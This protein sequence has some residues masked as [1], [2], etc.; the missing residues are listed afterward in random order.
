MA[1]GKQCPDDLAQENE[2]LR[3]RLRVLEDAIDNM[4]PGLC[5]F[6]ADRRI[7][8]C[9]PRFS[10]L[11][12]FPEGTIGP[13]MTSR[14]LVEKGMAVGDY[15]AG[16]T[17]D[18]L[19]RLLWHNLTCADAERQPL[20]R[21]GQ[22]FSA[23]PQRTPLGNLVTTFHDITYRTRTE[24]ALRAS[25][26]RLTA[27]L[28]AMPEAVGIYDTDGTLVYTNPQGLELLQADSLEQLAAA[29]TQAVASEYLDLC[30]DVHRRVIAGE[31]INWT[32]EMIG[33]KGRR[34]HVEANSVPFRAPDGAHQRMCIARDVTARER[35]QEALRLSEERLRLVQEATGLADFEVGMDGMVICSKRF[36][37]QTGLPVDTTRLSIE[38]WCKI[39][40]PEDLARV[41]EEI[42]AALKDLASDVCRNEFRIVRCDNGE[43]RW[44]SSLTTFQRDDRGHT[45]RSIGSHL[46]VTNRKHAEE[47]LRVSEERFRFAAEA[48]G[49]GVWD[50][51]PKTGQR[52]WSDRLMEILGLEPDVEPSLELASGQVHPA[53]REVFIERL[54]ELR[55]GTGPNRFTLSF[56]ITRA[57]DRAERWVA[58]NGWR[59]DRSEGFRRIILTARDV[60]EEKTAE[61]RIRWSASHDGLTRLANRSAFQDRLDRAIQTARTN[62]TQAGLLMIDLDHFK[63]INDALGHDAGDKLLQAFA[64]RLR[65]A[66]RLGD[67][68]ARFGGDE[69]AVLVPDLPSG[70]DLAEL[71]RSIHERLREP[72]IQ[73]GRLLDCRISVGAAIYPLHG[74]TPRDL[75]ISADMALYAAKTAGRS[76]TVEYRPELRHEVQRFASMVSLAR[77]AVQEDRILPFYQPQLDLGTGKIVGFEA[78]LRWRDSKNAVH[79][80]STIEAAFE[81]HEVAADISDRIIECAIGDMRLWLDDGVDFGHIAVNASA[82]EFRRDDFGERVLES[83]RRANI[84]S[85]YFQLEVTETVFLGRGAEFV[86]R[87]LGLLSSEG[88]KIALDDFGTGYASLRHLKQFPVDILKIDQ[89]FVRDMGKEPGDEAIIRAVVNLG[90]NLNIKVVAEGIENMRQAKRLI[91]LGCDF[92]QGFLFSKAVPSERVPP[93][94][95]HLPQRAREQRLRVAAGRV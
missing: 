5:V 41:R 89:S 40:H 67:T 84:P 39:I 64:Q 61:D 18:E 7:A 2:R 87:A 62:K 14:E 73:D 46:D 57:S 69:F 23:R 10:E 32:Y 66:V 79:L 70:Q 88:V 31:S 30:A 33:L 49:M 36:V 1:G 56:R 20:T 24:Q 22:V 17:A 53:D 59:A 45:V 9:N 16:M 90:K 43:V 95:S 12:G 72:F 80:P 77:R 38:E 83:L 25:E 47:A 4:I 6:D 81:D 91:E 3:A 65:G 58:I 42:A 94:L 93:L 19:D 85:R 92:G 63:Q 54:T 71:C 51:D 15:P 74:A 50:Y 68:V 48:A 13:G 11:L 78:L 21:G 82:A 35:N 37:E 27:I 28:G 52:E 86:H 29:G 75:L 60:T 8:A 26:A 34:F 44:I 55:D 76:T